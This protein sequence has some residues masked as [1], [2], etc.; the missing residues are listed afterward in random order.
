MIVL[1]D[2]FNNKLEFNTFI[3]LGSFDGLH[4]GHLSLI[5]KTVEL[6]NL[7]NAKSMVNTFANHPLSMIDKSRV[8]KIIMDNNTKTELLEKLNI[9]VVN[10]ADFDK[11]IM[12]MS[13]EDFIK[14]TIQYYNAVG[15]VVGFNHRFGYKN[16]G[17][18]KLLKD[19]SSKYNF[20]LHIVEPVKYMNDVISSTRIRKSIAEGDIACANKML[21]RPFSLSGKIISGKKIGRTIGFP[22]ANLE[23]Y[24]EFILPKIGVYYT[25]VE[26]NNNFYRGITDV[27]KNPTIDVNNKITIETYILDFNKDIYN[28]NLKLYFINRIRDEFK[29]NSLDGLIKQLKSDEDYARNQTLEMF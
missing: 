6:A 13:A 3:A 21:L 4:A 24:E 15:F 16:S 22:T 9:E 18:I 25:I 19:L 26:Y 17:N 14:N 28:E 23:Y 7:N 20:Q 5:E 29:F 27:G 10:Y 2:N 1:H 11:N 12:T 8:P